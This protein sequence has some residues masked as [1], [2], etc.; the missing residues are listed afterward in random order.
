LSEGSDAAPERP[1]C[2][3]RAALC[4]PAAVLCAFG[5]AGAL[6]LM[7][8]LAPRWIRPRQAAWVRAWGRSILAIFRVLVRGG[9][10]RSAPGAA[11]VFVHH[12]GLLDLM[13]LATQWGP[14]ATVIYKKE[15]HRV[16][17]IGFVMRRLGMIPINREDRESAVASIAA[18]AEL[19]RARQC[20]LFLA[21]EGTRSRGARLQEFKL[22]GFH[23][24]A[25]TGAPIQ[26][27]LMRGLEELNPRGSWLIRS[28]TVRLDYLE[29]IPT[30]GWTSEDAREHAERVRGVFLRH[31]EG[32]SG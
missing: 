21:P 15:F 20:K 32:S 25:A 3:L 24:A 12:V 8:L 26:P 23:L 13:V 2:R 29:P 9:E 19:V 22:G 14:D 11:L 7:Q 1:G 16:P 18:A 5:L 31:L 10:R 30:A 4:L 28:G 27:A 17:V 6:M